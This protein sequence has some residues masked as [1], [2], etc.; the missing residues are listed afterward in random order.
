[1]VRVRLRMG[2]ILL[3]AVLFVTTSCGTL[4]YPERRGQTEGR[5]DPAVAIMDG[6]GVLFFIIP[7]LVAF[8]VDFSTGCIYLPPGE[9]ASTVTPEQLLREGTV[10][11]LAD[12]TDFPASWITRHP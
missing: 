4:L 6:I 7:G 9:S 12:L 5:I 1:M 10:C 3:V 11:S 8:A 2:A